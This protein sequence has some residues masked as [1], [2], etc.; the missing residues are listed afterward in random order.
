MKIGGFTIGGGYAMMPIIQHEVVDVKKWATEE[1]MLDYLTIAQSMPGVI[2]INTATAVGNKV[3]GRRGAIAAT[4]GM[5]LPSFAVIV[6]VAAVFRR[7]QDNL[8]VQHA[9]N[10]MRAAVVALIL[11]A[12]IRIIKSAVTSALQFGVLASVFQ[13]GL[14][15]LT[16]VCIVFLGFAPQMMLIVCAAASLVYNARF[17]RKAMGLD[18]KGEK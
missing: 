15:V 4:C 17:T 10:G 16:F 1:E 12:I 14:V 2:S 9:F 8:L 7:L 13:I 3:A 18:N 6:I 5:V 11:V